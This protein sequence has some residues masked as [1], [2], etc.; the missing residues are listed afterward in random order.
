MLKTTTKARYCVL[1]SEA[2]TTPA[3][4]TPNQKF[5][6]HCMDGNRMELPNIQV[7]HVVSVAQTCDSEGQVL[8]EC[9]KL[10]NQA[11]QEPSK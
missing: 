2:V 4:L 7:G 10:H 3:G 1:K 11:S 5:L 8:K 9:F 6:Y